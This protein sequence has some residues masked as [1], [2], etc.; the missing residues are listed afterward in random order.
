MKNANEDDITFTF[1]FPF[2]T[3][4]LLISGMR[5][6][7]RTFLAFFLVFFDRFHFVVAVGNYG[8][9][10]KNVEQSS[11]NLD[12]FHLVVAVGSYGFHVKNVEQ[13]SKSLDRFHFVVAVGSYGFHVKNV[14]QSIK[15]GKK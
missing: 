5:G 12:R 7:H 15:K 10:V 4:N 2:S 6:S 13:S 14:E 3:F 1:N 11:K 8:F 9:H